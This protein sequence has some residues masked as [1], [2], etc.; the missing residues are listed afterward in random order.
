ML[1][2]KWIHRQENS[3]M[4]RK[5][6]LR[7]EHPFCGIHPETKLTGIQ[8]HNVSTIKAPLRHEPVTQPS[9]FMQ[10]IDVKLLH[11]K[12]WN[13]KFCFPFA[14]FHLPLQFF[15]THPVKF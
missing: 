13:F 7:E 5:C 2:C 9:L 3:R 11:N 14:E 4:T 10:L 1:R 15:R 6:C 8:I 12:R